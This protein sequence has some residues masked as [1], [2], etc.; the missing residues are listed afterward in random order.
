[1]VVRLFFFFRGD[2]TIVANSKPNMVIYIFFLL[3]KIVSEKKPVRYYQV[4]KSN[5]AQIG[6]LFYTT[7]VV[8]AISMLGMPCKINMAI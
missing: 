1:M 8:S 4:C 3:E 2:G 6:D 7:L 5:Q